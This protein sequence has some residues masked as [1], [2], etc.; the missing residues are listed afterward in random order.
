M[1]AFFPAE[2]PESSLEKDSRLFIQ[3][4]DDQEET[5]ELPTFLQK[6][7]QRSLNDEFRENAF[8][9][10]IPCLETPME[11]LHVDH[12][13]LE[14]VKFISLFISSNPISHL[15]EIEQLPSPSSKFKPC[16]SGPM[17]HIESLKEENLCAMDLPHTSTLESKRENSTNKH[18]NSEF[19]QDLCS[20]KETPESISLSATCSYQDH[21]HLLILPSKMYRRVVV[22]AFVYRKHYK[23]R[24]STM[25]LTLQ[26]KRNQ[27][28]VEKVGTMSPLLVVG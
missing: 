2:T 20:H 11:E 25:A 4:E 1:Q 13:L 22:N 19:P 17:S 8:A 14:E 28:M 9:T 15:C 26:L 24:G 16:P 27:R 18:E 23:F 3:E 12:D 5:F 7:S 21:N 10:P 6:Y